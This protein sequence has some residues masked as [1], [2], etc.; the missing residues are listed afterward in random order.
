M[1]NISDEYMHSKLATIKAYCMVLLKPGNNTTQENV[2]QILWEHGRRNF[3][4][5]EE[6]KISIV[7]PVSRDADV[8]GM[9]IF[10]T[11]EEEAV[12]IMKD[13]PAVKAGIFTCHT[14]RCMSFPGDSLQ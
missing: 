4:L 8:S 14:Y 11:S 7:C 6:G 12:T 10:N 13:D 5:R 2:Q 1:T 9:Y 3:A